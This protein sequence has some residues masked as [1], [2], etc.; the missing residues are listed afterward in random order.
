MK[1]NK[2]YRL[3]E[4]AIRGQDLNEIFLAFTMLI[5]QILICCSKSEEEALNA[6]ENFHNNLVG[7][8]QA[9]A[10]EWFTERKGN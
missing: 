9:N 7:S 3:M 8:I 5:S 1:P 10:T 2:I 6:A 4:K